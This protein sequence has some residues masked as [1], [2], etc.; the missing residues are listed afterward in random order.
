MVGGEYRPVPAAGVAG[1]VSGHRSEV[2]AVLAFIACTLAQV[3]RER[4][5]LRRVVPL[6]YQVAPAERSRA[7]YGRMPG[8]SGPP[9]YSPARS[10]QLVIRAPRSARAART[11]A[12]ATASGS[13][14]N[15]SVR[16]ARVSRP[17]ISRSARPARSSVARRVVPGPSPSWSKP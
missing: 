16:S 4:A 5:L 7:A 1:R 12:A 3:G 15:S 2:A 17:R 9:G 14:V 10:L 6:V 13:S 8:A 11:V